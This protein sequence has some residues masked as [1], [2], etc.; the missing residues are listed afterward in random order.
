MKKNKWRIALAVLAISGAGVY[1]YLNQPARDIASEAASYQVTKADLDRDYKQ[2]DSLA[3]QKY[4]DKT[5]E[6]TG[7]VSRV[8]SS[9]HSADVD[10][11]MVAIFKDSILPSSLKEKQK[12]TIKGRFVGY[13]DLMEEYKM[14]QVTLVN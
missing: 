9:T 10:E 3:D 7:V 5:I 13:D 4:L 11:N 8:I 14:D 6:Y 2:N 1:F 12:V